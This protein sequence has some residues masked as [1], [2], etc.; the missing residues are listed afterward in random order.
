MKFDVKIRSIDNSTFTKFKAIEVSKLI[1]YLKRFESSIVKNTKEGVKVLG[2]H[3]ST[4]T[5][6]K[7]KTN[8]KL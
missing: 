8:D 6:D 5:R 1:S 3:K 2:K 7:N 4:K